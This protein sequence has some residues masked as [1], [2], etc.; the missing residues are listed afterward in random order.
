MD[1]TEVQLS[2]N[3]L[4]Q[5]IGRLSDLPLVDMEPDSPGDVDN[6]DELAELPE[7]S[8]LA[9]DPLVELYHPMATLAIEELLLPAIVFCDSCKHIGIVHRAACW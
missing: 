4:V 6:V 8:E 3:V 9:P 7:A 2:E 5:V 1:Q